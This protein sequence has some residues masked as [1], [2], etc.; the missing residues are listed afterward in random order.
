VRDVASRLPRP[1]KELKGFARVALE[2]GQ[3][4]EARIELG[5]SAFEYYD[6]DQHRWVL[7]PGEFEILVG[8]S[9]ADIR[10]RATVHVG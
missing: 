2:P 6:P 5:P 1:P 10:A 4:G 3:S 9:A 8:T 7:E